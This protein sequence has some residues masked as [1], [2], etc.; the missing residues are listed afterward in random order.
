MSISLNL[1]RER[2]F[3]TSFPGA[4]DG[5]G[6]FKGLFAVWDGTGNPKQVSRCLGTGKPCLHVGK[7]SETGAR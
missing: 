1:G 7:I 4:R 2:E 3:P 6:K 5:N